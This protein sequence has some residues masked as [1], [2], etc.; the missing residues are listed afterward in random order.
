VKHHVREAASFFPC[1]FGLSPTSQQYFS[2]RT[3]KPPAT[4][5]QYFFLRPNQ[6][7]PNEQTVCSGLRPHPR[8][9]DVRV[10]ASHATSEGVRRRR[11]MADDVRDRRRLRPDLMNDSEGGPAASS[12]EAA[13]GHHASR[14]SAAA[15]CRMTRLLPWGSFL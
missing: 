1:S 11:P 15:G 7:Q 3:N 6:H 12:S 10:P 14:G 4:N 2:L 5:Q 13:A 8:A 9:C